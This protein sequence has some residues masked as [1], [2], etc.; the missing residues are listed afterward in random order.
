MF[1]CS[2]YAHYGGAHVFLDLFI[3]PTSVV[4][5]NFGLCACDGFVLIVRYS[6]VGVLVARGCGGNA[7]WTGSQAVYGVG[8]IGALAR[9][10][11]ADVWG[12]VWGGLPL[13]PL[14]QHAVTA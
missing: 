14:L 9:L 10:T 1:S 6:V 3:L 5:V 2:L 8:W 7:P 13:K 11:T 4:L 12:R